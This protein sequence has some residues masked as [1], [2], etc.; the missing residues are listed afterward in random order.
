MPVTFQAL[1]ERERKLWMEAMDGKEPV[2]LF[3]LCWESHKTHPY[4]FQTL[5]INLKFCLSI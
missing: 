4:T 1:S 2:S 3:L 5:R